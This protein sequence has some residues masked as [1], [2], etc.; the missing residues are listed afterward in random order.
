MAALWARV[1]DTRRVSIFDS[2]F[3]LG[4]SSLLA[5]RLIALVRDQFNANISMRDFLQQPHVAG[6]CSL[7]GA[8]QGSAADLAL[9]TPVYTPPAPCICRDKKIHTPISAMKGSH[10]TKSDTN[11]G[12]LS[13]CGRAVIDTPLL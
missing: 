9:E 11:H 7:M 3:D 1:L 12:T 10:E 8:A 5:A 2:F 6:L 13:C 4:G